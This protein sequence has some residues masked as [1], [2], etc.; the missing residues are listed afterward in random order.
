MEGVS[1]GRQERARAKWALVGGLNDESRTYS[2]SVF[3]GRVDLFT[4]WNPSG[5][6]MKD[7]REEEYVRADIRT[8]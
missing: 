7:C 8:T 6:D 2:L 4:I 3:I 5:D 1:W